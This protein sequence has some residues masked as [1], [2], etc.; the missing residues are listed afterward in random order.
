MTVPRVRQDR[1][2]A[3]VYD[4]LG[5]HRADK[6]QWNETQVLDELKACS[7]TDFDPEIVELFSPAAKRS[8]A[9]ASGILTINIPGN[10]GS[11]G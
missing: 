9:S 7:G 4:A 2:L 8:A 1:G 6:E 3:D 10:P 11:T 5:S